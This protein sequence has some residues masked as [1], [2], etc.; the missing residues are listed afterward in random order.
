MKENN[1]VQINAIN[2]MKFN[3]SNSQDPIISDRGFVRQGYA[4]IVELLHDYGFEVIHCELDPKELSAFT[5]A[6][7]KFLSN[8]QSDKIMCVNKMQA[9]E[10]KIF[11]L[12]YEF[13]LY[14][15]N[16]D[17]QCASSYFHAYFYNLEGNS[18]LN[19][20][21]F[22][23]A[24]NLLVPELP[25]RLEYSRLHGTVKDRDMVPIMGRRFLVP[26]SVISSRF[27]DFGIGI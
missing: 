9:M 10:N 17:K 18:H 22:E 4:P 16:S 19:D 15:F 24:R 1:G 5:V 12:A 23:F 6:G 13:G 11:A 14:L 25:F 2:Q 20:S 27:K 3:S 8:L 26:D 21:A 7:R